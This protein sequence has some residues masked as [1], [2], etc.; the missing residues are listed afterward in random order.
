MDNQLLYKLVEEVRQQAHFAQFAFQNVR[1]NLVASD[2]ERVFFYV[3]ALI[4]HVA[5]ISRLLWPARPE[6]KERGDQLRAELK[7]DESSPLRLAGFRQ[8]VDQFDERLEDWASALEHRNYMDMNIMPLGT[9]SNYKQ[10]TFQRNLAPERFQFW[11]R[12]DACD[13]RAL[14]EELRKLD[15]AVEAW[16]RTHHFW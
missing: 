12:G 14:A 13:L 16:L 5:N 10:D 1:D 3:H 4:A 7:V 11:F 9:I 2:S 15:S 8:Q 6:S